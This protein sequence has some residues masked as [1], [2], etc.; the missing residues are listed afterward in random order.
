MSLPSP[1]LDERTFTELYED[2][3]KL[4]PRFAPDWTDHNASDPGITLVELLAWL[5]EAQQYYLNRT[6]NEHYLKFL[7]LLGVRLKSAQ[8]AKSEV[9]YQFMDSFQ[10]E[11]I[12]PKGTRLSA[13]EV[14]FETGETLTVLPSRLKK[15]ISVSDRG[16]TDNSE[17][18]STDGLYYF[19]FGEE[20][21]KGG[22]LYIGF[23]P[24]RPL[25]ANKLVVLTFSLLGDGITSTKPRK[26]LPPVE[27]A[28]E[29]LKKDRNS[30]GV[31][32]PLKILKDT[33][34]MLTKSG[35]LYFFAPRDMEKRSLFHS[36]EDHYWL[37]ATIKKGEYELVPKLY[38]ILLN[39]VTVLQKK[40]LSE[41]FT[42]SGTSQKKYTFDASYLNLKG[43][44][45]IQILKENGF[46]R[47]L[48][49]YS[50]EKDELQCRVSITFKGEVPEK[51]RKNIRLISWQPGFAEKGL[52]G[53]GNGLPNQKLTLDNKF[54][55]PDR[56]ILQ[57]GEE[58]EENGTKEINWRDWIRVDDFDAS[59][60]VDQHFVL[61]EEK[62]EIF[63][64]NGLNGAIP[65]MP[66]DSEIKNIRLVSFQTGGGSSGNIP[67][68]SINETISLT[69]YN[70]TVLKATNYF[71]AAGGEDKETSEEA[72]FRLRKEL[73]AGYRAVTSQDYERLALAAPGVKVARAKAVP[74]FCSEAK[75]YPQE[76]QPGVVTI[77]V[78]PDSGKA[79]SIP[80]TA[81]LQN[82]HNYLCS[83]RLITTKICLIPPLYIEVGVTAQVIIKSGYSQS[84]L[85][86][87][88]KE[89]LD[90]FL[91]PLTGGMDGKGWPFGRS[92]YQSEIYQAIVNLPGVD[93]VNEIVLS[94]GTGAESDGKGN[95]SI[96]PQGLICPGE[97]VVEIVADKSACRAKGA[98]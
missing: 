56:I 30:S 51:G 70:N 48:S 57:V 92:I 33:A 65:P 69:G 40:T 73:K 44:N 68:Y 79:K 83:H 8:P 42:F 53:A 61:D 94:A 63:F 88:I 39:T 6:R 60:P 47:D 52:I 95:Y 41:V 89:E 16:L 78:V 86:L 12:I 17:A 13:K 91:H 85:E 80:G 46:W 67:Q 7:K 87:K 14:I 2:A 18:N 22:S 98:R 66:S 24:E 72:K 49:E 35:K 31:W 96:P 1:N 50:I 84:N 81:F 3:K 27:I 10:K 71:M 75:N 77:V 36:E 55:L 58:A 82:V 9:A 37:R 43:I 29:Y 5:A 11:V 19:A 28:C 20:A 38:S 34:L 25:P 21:K 26:L 45:D 23:D 32:A 15:V 90:R 62:G 64:G 97:H 54:V 4:I 93:Y 74:L 59:G 76:I